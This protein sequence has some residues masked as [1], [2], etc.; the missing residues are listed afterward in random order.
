MRVWDSSYQLT[1]DEEELISLEQED[2]S[3]FDIERGRDRRPR[4]LYA[5][6]GYKAWLGSIFT[7]ENKLVSDGADNTIVVHDFSGKSDDGQGF[8]Y[9]GEEEDEMEGFSFE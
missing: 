2:D 7:N 1:E 6:T 8:L 3:G 4:C 9:E 5:L